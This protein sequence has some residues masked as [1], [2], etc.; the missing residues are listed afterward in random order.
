M[1]PRIPRIK[2]LYPIYRVD[3]REI[4]IGAEPH[5]T[6]RVDDTDGVMSAFIEALDGRTTTEELVHVMQAKF[7]EATEA[8]VMD[9]VQTLIDLN[10]IEDAEHVP[11]NLTDHELDRHSRNIK[12][13]EHFANPE[14][15]KYT[16]Q[17]RLKNAKVCVLGLG[18][19]GSAIMFQLASLG[20]GQLVAVDFDTLELSNLNRLTW[21]TTRDLGK[22][23]TEVVTARL[24]EYAPEVQVATFVARVGDDVARYAQGCDLIICCIDQPYA[25]IDRW[26][27]EAA[28]TLGIPCIF[29]AHFTMTGRY[30]SIQP[31]V[32][33]C[34]DCML[35]KFLREDPNFENQFWALAR[36]GRV[37]HA[38]QAVIG[39]NVSVLAGMI[40]AETIRYLAGTQPPL[41]T[42]K[43]MIVD[44]GVMTGREFF[45]WPRYDDCPS[46]GNGCK[47]DWPFFGELEEFSRPWLATPVLA[48]EAVTG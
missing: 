18:G 38:H 11:L 12:Y 14:I 41:S 9:G 13:F 1:I 39:P 16:Y 48:P 4:R 5:I 23:K 19:H 28:L 30:Y 8:D 17:E 20:V 42:G 15:S 33:G 35:G 27:N 40:A 6:A 3:D 36:D 44:F 10:F 22:Q 31:G 21:Y 7:P 47:E 26:V 25:Q 34:I 2:S 46:C 24:A 37:R 45:N 32:S 43:M 29:S